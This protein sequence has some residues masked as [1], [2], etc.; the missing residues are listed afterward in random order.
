M[1]G[2]EMSLSFSPPS[3]LGSLGTDLAALEPPP[4]AA[5]IAHDFALCADFQRSLATI[6][7]LGDTIRVAAAMP[8]LPQLPTIPTNL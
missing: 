4:W 7:R 1:K 6:N 8:A 2:S 5:M 3:L